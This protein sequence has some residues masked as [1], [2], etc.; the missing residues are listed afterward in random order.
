M[1]MT[2]QEAIKHI[3]TCYK[4]DVSCYHTAIAKGFYGAANVHRCDMDANEMAL[5]ALREKAE[6]EDP[7]PLTLE[8]LQQM[9]GEPV[10]VQEAN[11]WAIVQAVDDDDGNIT[12]FV[13]G[14][15]GYEKCWTSFTWKVSE[16]KLH[17]YRHKPKEATE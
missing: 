10:W 7:K 8:E 15:F 4:A 12:P 3:A 2:I 16:R 9:D 13:S 5:A 17:C 6:R 11:K 1:S 14:T